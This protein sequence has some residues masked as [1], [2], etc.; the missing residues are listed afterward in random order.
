MHASM[1]FS[2]RVVFLLLSVL[3]TSC[4]VQFQQ[5]ETLKQMREDNNEVSPEGFAWSAQW[6]G[7][8]YTLYPVSLSEQET[9]FAYD[10][11]LY[12]FFTNWTLTRV[13]GFLPEDVEVRIEPQ[14]E[15]QLYFQ[16]DQLLARHQC[17]PWASSTGDDGTLHY[18]QSCQGS[19]DYSNEVDVNSAGAVVRVSYLLH[20]DYPPLTMSP[21][22]IN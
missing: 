10:K 17:E 14:G 7:S 18:V 22:N 20:P 21:N 2:M 16:D 15:E 4:S 13:M 3:L 5:L 1:T 9:V 11:R 8:N 19:E 6:N 12:L